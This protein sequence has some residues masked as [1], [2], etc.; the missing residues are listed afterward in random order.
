MDTA[1]ACFVGCTTGDGAESH[2]IW[3][4]RPTL[5]DVV[6]SAL[7]I[8]D[9]SLFCRLLEGPGKVVVDIV[10]LEQY[11]LPFVSFCADAQTAAVRYGAIVRGKNDLL[12]ASTV[13]EL[14]GVLRDIAGG[15][16]S[17]EIHSPPC[18]IRAAG[19]TH[20]WHAV[21]HWFW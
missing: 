5:H 15:A 3:T 8:M 14:I 16:T 2:R 12:A 13:A 11:F 18:S 7:P 19:P 17:L 6:P 9:E 4:G 21:S 20:P 1:S 10:M